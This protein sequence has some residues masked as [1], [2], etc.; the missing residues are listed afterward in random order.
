MSAF[1]DLKRSLTQYMFN[2][3]GGNGETVLTSERY[4]SK[5]G[6]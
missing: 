6:A 5:Q 3:K 2:L 4:T 1:F